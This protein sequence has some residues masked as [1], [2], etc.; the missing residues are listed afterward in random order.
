M[1]ITIKLIVALLFMFIFNIKSDAKTNI[2]KQVV[3]NEALLKRC[4]IARDK[5]QHELLNR[6][7]LQL[8]KQAQ[9]SDDLRCEAFALFYCGLSQLFLGQGEDGLS[10]LNKSEDLAKQIENDSII[11]LTLN[12]KAIY[13][14]MYANNLFIAQRYFLRSLETANRINYEELRARVYGNLI[15]LSHSKNDTTGLENAQRIYDYG[16]KHKKYELQYLGTYYIA[17][18]N[19]LR[20]NFDEAEKHLLDAIDIFKRY[21]YED[22]PSVYTLYSQVMSQKGNDK[23]AEQLALEA[24]RLA[25]IYHQKSL[26]S[27]AQLQYAK[28]LHNLGQYEKSNEIVFEALEV[29]ENQNKTREVD[30]YQLIAKNYQK[31]GKNDLAFNYIYRANMAMDTLSTVNMD[32]LMHERAIMLD[33][34]KKEQE[35]I[36]HEQR[37][38]DQRRLNIVLTVAVLLMLALLF[39]IL[40]LYNKRNS[41]YKSIVK[42][43]AKAAKREI[44]LQDRLL[45]T[46]EQLVTAEQQLATTQEQSTELLKTLNQVRKELTER[47]KEAKEREEEANQHRQAIE[48]AQEQARKQLERLE[49]RLKPRIEEDKAQQLYNKLCLLMERDRIYTDTQ[50]N[51]ERVAEALGTNRTYLS[52]IIKE[53]SGMSYLQFINSYRI[54]DA[55]RILSDREQINYPLKQICSDLGFNSPV[56]F[57]KLFQQAVGITP[58]VYRKQFVGMAKE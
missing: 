47:E 13:H 3:S 14:A 26:L 30:C 39:Y 18:Y 10:L 35:A 33:I 44:E 36:L 5:S 45:S 42:Q 16:I 23:K 49:H 51:R 6:L 24:I 22:I 43:N 9:A 28:V 15:I 11:A 4:D 7:S 8:Y 32:R 38:A 2:R 20:G 19:Q 31:L 17:M 12:A 37:I 46:E 1:R 41:L 53:K 50:L 57:Y 58:S 55:I 52:Q 56:T 40:H 34:E 54:N 21:P 29:I 27:D 48:E 25:K